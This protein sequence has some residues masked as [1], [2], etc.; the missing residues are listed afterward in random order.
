MEIDGIKAK[1]R[2]NEFVFSDHAVQEA[3]EEAI[4]IFEIKSAILNGEILEQNS[5]TGRDESCLI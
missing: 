4:D 1:V 2:D 5:D 3:A